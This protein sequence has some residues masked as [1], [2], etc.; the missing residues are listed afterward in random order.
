MKSDFGILTTLAAH[1][2][3]LSLF[4]IGGANAAI[5][6][7]HRVAVELHGWMTDRQ[8]T[9]MFAIAQVTP[10][11]NVII[12][13]LIGYHVAGLPGALVT[14]A[15]M[16]GP[17]CVVAYYVGRVWERFRD[18]RWRVAIQA[19]LV[20]VSVGLIAASAWILAMTGDHNWIAAG[21]TI[22]TAIV[23]YFS[24][25]NPLWLFAPAA[26]IGLFGYL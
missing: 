7:M 20:P 18:A 10:G 24:K 9:D 5:P 4:A 1:F 23:G 2:A 26:L 14:T 13:T 16:C 19:G 15:A 12:V 21:I 22:A 25:L 6:E 11:P 8:F 17:T 3:L